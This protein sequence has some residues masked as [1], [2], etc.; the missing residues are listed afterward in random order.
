MIL[1]ILT[2]KIFQKKPSFSLILLI[3]ILSIKCKGDHKKDKFE[4]QIG[5]SISNLSEADKLVDE[6]I[7][8]FGGMKNWT[9]KKSLSYMKTINSYDS[10][11]SL[12]RNVNQ[13]HKYQLRPSFKANITWEQDGKKHEKG[14]YSFTDGSQ[15]VG[16]W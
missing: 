9:S 5:P 6:T 7:A 11:G 8:H 2:L 3:G 4:I 14:S 10:L 13:S 15:Y 16:E 12:I 1:K